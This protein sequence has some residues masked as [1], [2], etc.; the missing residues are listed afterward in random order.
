MQF[1]RTKMNY[2]F[3]AS[4][5]L[6]LFIHENDI[7]GGQ[8]GWSRQTSSSWVENTTDFLC[9]KSLTAAYMFMFIWVI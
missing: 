1:I 3:G 7:S 9:E 2:D 8:T 6:Q 4:Q 5:N